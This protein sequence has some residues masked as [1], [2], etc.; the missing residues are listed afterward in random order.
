[1]P[2][3]SIWGEPLLVAGEEQTGCLT[4]SRC[5]LCTCNSK[6]SLCESVNYEVPSVVLQEV[7]SIISEHQLTDQLQ[8]KGTGRDLGF[9][10]RM[11]VFRIKCSET[12]RKKAI[13]YFHWIFSLCCRLKWRYL[14]LNVNLMKLN[15]EDNDTKIQSYLKRSLIDEVFFKDELWV[16][17]ICYRVQRRFSISMSIHLS[18]KNKGTEWSQNWRLEEGQVHGAKEWEIV[19]AALLGCG[20]AGDFDFCLVVKWHC[21]PGAS[22]F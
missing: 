5:W 2:W 7:W 14:N 19:T 4:H 22:S 17:H 8:L 11:W 18:W 13:Y 15:T 6:V 9:E 21:L 1:M 16:S 12:V 10:M 3:N 20:S